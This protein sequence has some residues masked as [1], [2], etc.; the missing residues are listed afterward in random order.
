MENNET[1][2]QYLCINKR[3]PSETRL[4]DA[5]NTLRLLDHLSDAREY[6]DLFDDID[7]LYIHGTVQNGTYERLS[8]QAILAAAMRG[9]CLPHERD[10]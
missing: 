8:G 3:N 7:V 4:I 10:T 9:E 5:K 2:N 6:Y 1:I